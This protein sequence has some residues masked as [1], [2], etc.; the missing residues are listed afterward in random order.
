[1][2]LLGD[3]N[4]DVNARRTDEGSTPLDGQYSIPSLV[5][6]WN[7]LAAFIIKRSHEDE[8]KV[9]ALEMRVFSTSILELTV[10]LSWTVM[11]Q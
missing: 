5:R 2:K 7:V 8:G 6:G 3:N 1:M 11:L 9:A 10:E 4:A